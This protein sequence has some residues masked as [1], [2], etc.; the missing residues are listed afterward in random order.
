[1][2]LDAARQHCTC[3]FPAEHDPKLR[4]VDDVL[5]GLCAFSATAAA[6]ALSVSPLTPALGGALG[7]AGA[8]LLLLL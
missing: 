8:M 5:H 3:A 2:G 1:M 4:H 6:L 7:A